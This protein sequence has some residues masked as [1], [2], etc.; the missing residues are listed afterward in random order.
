MSPTSS[1][2]GNPKKNG[3]QGLTKEHVPNPIII[4]IEEAT[5]K[6]YTIE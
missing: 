6:E 2:R 5:R 3:I 1:G 4:R